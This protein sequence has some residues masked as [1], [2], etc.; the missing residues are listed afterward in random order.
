MRIGYVRVSSDEQNTARQEEMMKDLGVEKVYIDRAS[1]KN[2]DRAQLKAMLSYVRE[3]DVVVVSE[4][5]RLARNTM[6]LLGIIDE[7]TKKGVGF[8]SQKERIDTE[9]PTGKFM[10][11]VFGAVAEL[12]RG[13]IRSR[14]REG[15]ELA[16][17]RGVYKGRPQS[18]V[19]EAKFLAVYKRWKAGEITGVQARAEL[20]MKNNKFYDTVKRYEQHGDPNFVGK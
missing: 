17:A 19:D 13:Y 6:D 15:I 20:G 18:K 1:G 3:G 4:I 5:S 10:L 8:E 11:T 9:T 12:E 7:L 2:T 16:K 14:Q